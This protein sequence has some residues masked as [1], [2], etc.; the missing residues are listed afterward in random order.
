MAAN[1]K[2]LPNLI[3]PHVGDYVRGQ[4]QSLMPLIEKS[5]QLEPEKL[6]QIAVLPLG[7]RVLMDPWSSRLDLNRAPAVPLYWAREKL[8]LAIT[9]MTPYLKYA[10]QGSPAA[11]R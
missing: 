7:A 5:P 10:D 3:Q 8:P 6:D 1:A 4:E 11:T 9:P 2:S